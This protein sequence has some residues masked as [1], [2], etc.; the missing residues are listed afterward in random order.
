MNILSKVKV[1]KADI[2]TLKVDCIVNAANETLLGLGKN[3]NKYKGIAEAIRL[4]AGDEIVEECKVLSRAG[5]CRTGQAVITKGYK[6]PAKHVIHA[7]GPRKQ[8]MGIN[9]G[10]L[11]SAYRSSLDVMKENKLRSIA[12]CCISTGLFR[13]P[14]QRSAEVAFK[15]V[16]NWLEKNWDSVD[17]V[18]F[19]TW[20]DKD[21]IIY[22]N[23]I[24]E[25]QK[26]QAG[27]MQ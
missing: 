20:L 26:N 4:A 18:V 1:V 12:F 5:G 14:N 7:V 21:D 10:L 11:A 2:T 25:Y 8:T 23:L 16:C 19:C 3:K 15:T 27:A 6:L 24:A 17:E 13:H 9:Y 22:R